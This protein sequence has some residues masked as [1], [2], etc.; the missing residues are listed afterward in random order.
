MMWPH[1]RQRIGQSYSSTSVSMFRHHISLSLPLSLPHFLPFFL[2][3]HRKRSGY[4]H[5][6]I[7]QQ[8]TKEIAKGLK[9]NK[10][11]I[12]IFFLYCWRVFT[13]S[14]YSSKTSVIE[15]M[16]FVNTNKNPNE[17]C[18]LEL[19]AFLFLSSTLFFVNHKNQQV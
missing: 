10:R 3:M 4:I 1:V 15:K 17:S 2:Q 7:Q 19:Q 14:T 11:G 18:Q 5:I 16:T 9:K 12:S 6:K 13:M 8:L